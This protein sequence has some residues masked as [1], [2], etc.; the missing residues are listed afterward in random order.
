MCRR[1]HFK[2]PSSLLNVMCRR[3]NPRTR[4]CKSPRRKCRKRR[5]LIQYVTK[6]LSLKR[7]CKN[8]V[9]FLPFYNS[10]S[11]YVAWLLMPKVYI[12]YEEEYSIVRLIW[13][14]CVWGLISF[15]FVY[16]Y[17][18]SEIR[19]LTGVAYMLQPN[20][21]WTVCTNTLLLLAW[22]CTGT[23]RYSTAYLVVSCLGGDWLEW[24]CCSSE[25][26]AVWKLF[27]CTM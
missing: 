14:L 11:C 17:V 21:F 24:K 16:I 23:F 19:K 25:M 26:N 8:P 3:I 15:I 4:H 10:V 6:F 2:W 13:H 20:S 9:Q 12:P 18:C 27:D 7:V 5:N 1:L 22:T